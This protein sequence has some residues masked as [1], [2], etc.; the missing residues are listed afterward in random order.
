MNPKLFEQ[1]VKQTIQKYK[2]LEKGDKVLVASSGGKDST[3]VLYLLHKFGYKPEALHINLRMGKWSEENLAN[4][5]QFC[6]NN[7]ISLHVFDIRKLLGY[8][9]CYIKEVVRSRSKLK[10]CTI[11]GVLRRW[12]LNRL[13]RK[14][15][16][17][18]IATGHNLDDASQTVLMNWF[19]GNLFIGANEGP[20]VGIVEDKKFVQRIKPLYFC[21]EKDVEAYSK[22]MNFPVLYQRCPCVQGAYRHEVRNMLNKLK[23]ENNDIK[24]SIVKNFLRILPKLRQ[25]VASSNLRYCKFC[26]EPSRNEACK[27]CLIIQN[28]K[29][30]QNSL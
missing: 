23:K 4:L 10:Q 28:F 13:A 17:D 22:S 25:Q 2:L 1:K 11:C 16:A 6:K 29:N 3:T 14:L 24:A 30:T 19:K 26:G 15:Q 12:L 7:G 20:K 9:I 8:S 21:L 5:E 27:A 18:K